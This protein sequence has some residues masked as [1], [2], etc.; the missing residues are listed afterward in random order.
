MAKMIPTVD[1]NTLLN[2]N[3]GE[4]LVYDSLSN[5]SGA[6]VFHSV[7][8]RSRSSGRAIQGEG[9][10]VVYLPNRGVI[11]LEVKSSEIRFT[12]GK[13]YQKNRNQGVDYEIGSPLGQADRT[14]FKLLEVFRNNNIDVPI[15]SAVWFP[16]SH[17]VSGELPLE[18]DKS[19]V[20]LK[21]DLAKPQKALER[22]FDYC[23]FRDHE[24][25]KVLKD[26]LI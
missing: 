7:N 11:A 20:L 26:K 4:T 9:D 21:N 1:K 25:S 15:I 14:R 13:W 23:G 8:W 19:L 24:T 22:A 10:F 12:D 5:V 16:N 2:S 3:I 6:I 17:G 18:Y